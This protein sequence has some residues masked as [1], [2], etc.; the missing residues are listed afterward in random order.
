ME[1]GNGKN[2]GKEEEHRFQLQYG[3][4]CV[5]LNPSKSTISKTGVLR[6]I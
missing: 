5:R 1:T 3:W 4:E 2:K 6:T